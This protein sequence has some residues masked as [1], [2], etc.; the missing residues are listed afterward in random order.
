MI[1]SPMIPLYFFVLL[2]SRPLVLNMAPCNFN[3]VFT[4]HSG[5]VIRTLTMPENKKSA[6][7]TKTL[8]ISPGLKFVQTT[9]LQHF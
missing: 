8:N 1:H 6:V 3:R 4:T 7:S 2:F 9:L 5:V